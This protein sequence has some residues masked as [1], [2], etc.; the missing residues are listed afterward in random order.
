MTKV[1]VFTKKKIISD[2]RLF[3]SESQ[4]EYG[5]YITDSF[6]DKKLNAVIKRVVVYQTKEGFF[7]LSVPYGTISDASHREVAAQ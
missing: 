4:N 1:L 6:G 2:I 5:G 3:K 7:E